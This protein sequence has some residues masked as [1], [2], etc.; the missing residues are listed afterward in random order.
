MKKLL[1]IAVVMLIYCACN[2]SPYGTATKQFQD[3]NINNQIR[4]PTP[5]LGYD[6]TR[7]DVSK[8]NAPGDQDTVDS[9]GA[10]NNDKPTPGLGNDPTRND[11]S[12]RFQAPGDKSKLPQDSMKK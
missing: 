7:N 2:E 5:G 4:D 11:A 12:N 9:T 6:P 8:K 3:T 1:V 10:V